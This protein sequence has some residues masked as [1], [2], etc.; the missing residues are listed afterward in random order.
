ML[1][2]GWYERISC[3]D[4]FDIC[5]DIVGTEND[6]HIDAKVGEKIQ[7]LEH[8]NNYTFIVNFRNVKIRFGGINEKCWNSFFKYVDEDEE[9]L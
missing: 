8:R 2:P 9:M 3:K 6:T 4:Y 5:G 1:K 7:L